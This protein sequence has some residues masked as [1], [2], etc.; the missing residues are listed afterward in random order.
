MAI[1]LDETATNGIDAALGEGPA[2]PFPPTG[3]FDARVD[4]TPYGGIFQT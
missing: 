4:L 2:P 3:A 1:G